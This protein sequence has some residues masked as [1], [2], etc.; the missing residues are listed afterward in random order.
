[1]FIGGEEA[2][3]SVKQEG[4]EVGTEVKDRGDVDGLKA[5]E[6]K[7]GEVGSMLHAKFVDGW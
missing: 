6:V 5:I 3:I 1:M 4:G 2:P 7:V